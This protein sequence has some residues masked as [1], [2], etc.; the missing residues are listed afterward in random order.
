MKTE[1]L[2][3]KVNMRNN[4]WIALGFGESM[5][6]T[7]MMGWHALGENSYTA[8]YW[9][10]RNGTPDWDDNNDLNT[11]HVVEPDGRVTFTTTRKLD[12]GDS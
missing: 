12:T 8:D 7:D 2:Q 11:T 3:F 5:F 9:A 6:N 10:T 1:E 4:S